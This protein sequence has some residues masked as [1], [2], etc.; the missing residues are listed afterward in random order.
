MERLLSHLNYL[1]MH[2]PFYMER[3]HQATSIAELPI[4]TKD[5]IRKQYGEF[6]SNEF[7]EVK[8]RLVEFVQNPAIQ[9]DRTDNE[10]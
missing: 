9:K 1:K 6:F 10:L 3:N 2:V 4:M 7:A 8:D 5:M